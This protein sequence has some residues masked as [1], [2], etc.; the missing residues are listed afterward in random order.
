MWNLMLFP[1]NVSCCLAGP[2]PHPG[3]KLAHQ[4]PVHT[5]AQGESGEQPGSFL[6]MEVMLPLLAVLASKASD[7]RQY[8]PCSHGLLTPCLEETQ[9][10]KD[11]LCSVR[12]T[13][14]TEAPAK[15]SSNCQPSEGG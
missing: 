9:A 4:H 1:L 10:H 12:A 8:P 3:T 14:P 11:V 7:V 13:V 2:S 15:I 5:P 6:I